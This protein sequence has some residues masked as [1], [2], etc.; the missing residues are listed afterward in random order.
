[1][2]TPLIAE[3]SIDIGFAD[4]D[5]FLFSVEEELFGIFQ[6]T[7]KAI[8]GIS[9]VNQL[10]SRTFVLVILSGLA[11]DLEDTIEEIAIG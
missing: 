11:E 3:F 10:H 2:Y 9:D 5:G 7:S 6:W 8:N 1:M 4:I